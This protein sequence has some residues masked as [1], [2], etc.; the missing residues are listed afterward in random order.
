M[1]S[2]VSSKKTLTFAFDVGHSSIGWSVIDDSP[3]ILG[4]GVVTFP[5]DD[6]LASE[7]R[8][9]R[10]QRRHIRATR[11]RIMRIERLLAHLEVLTG[12]TI[13]RKHSPGGGHSAPW[14][15]AARVLRGGPLLSW[16]ELW[17]VLRWYAHNRGYDGNA[18]WSKNDPL[19]EDDD[20]EKLRNARSLLEKYGT[21]TMAETFCAIS[22]L[23]PLS[24]KI[25]CNLPGNQRPKAQ[26]AAFPRE[27]VVAEV[28]SILER[29][30]GKL[31]KLDAAFIKTLIQ[32]WKA[33]PCPTIQLPARYK[34]GLLFGQLIPRFDN[35][36]IG[37]CPF[38][39]E[40]VYQ[41]TLAAT[42][43]ESMARREAL[44]KAKL[45]KKTCI[46]FYRY[47]WAMLV[48]NIRV[49]CGSDTQ[50][51][52]LT[53]EERLQLDQRMREKGFL[54]AGELKKVIKEVVPDATTNVEQLLTHP[55]AEE[56]FVIDPARRA[57]YKNTVWR[58]VFP[59]LPVALQKRAIGLL[60]KGCSVS[61]ADLLVRIDT[62]PP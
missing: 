3:S 9:F 16:E 61:L 55:D 40:K 18:A 14:L 60:R 38:T 12:E 5:K 47:R 8:Q 43:D 26:N 49:A 51:R 57:I 24:N 46:E 4:C 54:T 33:I 50:S 56:A 32:D 28:T 17:D 30:C 41:S 15:L 39:Y 19:E 36:I 58:E 53:V 48:A 27:N 52:S 45:P 31:P 6:C 59:H 42:G 44:K 21:N 62:R 34:G 7:R 23:D 37:H 20:R 2:P 25:S 10:R 22:G 1:P 13:A 11:L 29:H 35:R